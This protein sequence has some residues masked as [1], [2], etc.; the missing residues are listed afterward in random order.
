MTHSQTLAMVAQQPL[1]SAPRPAAKPRKRRNPSPL[2]TR[3]LAANLVALAIVV[4]G[5]LYLG[6]F[7]RGLLDAKAAALRTQGEI[8][9]GALGETVVTQTLGEAPSID[10]EGA[11]QMVRRLVAPIK[12]RARLFDAHG[13]LVA[14]SWRL[15]SVGGIVETEELAPPS[16]GSIRETAENLLRTADWGVFGWVPVEPA[17][18]GTSDRARDY[19]EAMEALAGESASALRDGGD[20]GLILSV[21]VPVQRFKQVQG[22]LMLSTTLEDVVARV[23]EVRY[24]ILLLSLL[25]LA[26]TVLLSVFLAGTIARPVRRLAAAADAVR[27]RIDRAV[28]IPDFS[29]RGD[30]IGDLSRSLSDMTD[31]LWSRMDAIKNFAADV[32]HEI[33]N[34]LSSLRSAVETA[35]RVKDPEQQKQLMSIILEDVQRLD[36]LI[37]DIA[38]ASRLDAELSRAES[39]PVLIAKMLSALVEIYLTTGNQSHSSL[40]LDIPEGDDLVVR[41]VEHRLVQVFQNLIDN[42]R[43]FS[44]PDGVVRVLAHRQGNWVEIAVE[45]DGPGLPAAKLSAV[46]DRFYSERPAGEKFGTH[47]GLGLSISKQIVEAHGGQIIAE[48]R[49]PD[50]GN[51]KGAR[52]IV[53]LPC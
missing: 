1:D 46:F 2:I 45:D 18:T 38:G 19:R 14:D 20:L 13:T 35:A 3:I 21:A 34:P 27:H 40:V 9:A 24:R 17:T 5:V 31:T 30:E 43:S 41:G 51:P 48:N 16:D 26:A 10:T 32:S 23:A 42:A 52:F 6:D 50:G 15:L 28:T 12:T 49:G 36:R 37:S 44:P 4:G 53:R 39:T 7:G 8:I 33:K 22:A 47:S 29:A 25:A 11:W